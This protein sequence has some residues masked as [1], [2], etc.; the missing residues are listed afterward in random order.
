MGVASG[1]SVELTTYQLQ[2]VAH[3]WFKQWKSER[4][5]DAGP[6]EWEE[7]A[8]AFLDRFFPLEL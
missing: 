8:S 2:D 4:P 3:V 5:D 7:F 1:E 6:V